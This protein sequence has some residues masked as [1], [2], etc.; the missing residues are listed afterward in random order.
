MNF[1]CIGLIILLLLLITSSYAQRHGLVIDSTNIS[2]SD[3]IR[4]IHAADDGIEIESA[5]DD[6]IQIS[7]ARE[8]GYYIF[9]A[10]K[11]GFWVFN[12]GED[13]VFVENAGHNG[14]RIKSTMRD[15]IHVES[16]LDD[17]VHLE[18]VSDD[19]FQVDNAGGDGIYI[20]NSDNTGVQV[21]RA[22]RN[23]VSVS[24]SG[25][26]GVS[27]GIAGVD[28]VYVQ[29]A[30]DDGI[31]VNNAGDDGVYI[32]SAGGDG[33]SVV[34]A[35]E[36]SMNIGGNKNSSG[37]PDAHIAQIYN[38]STDTS[39]DVLALKVGRTSNLG[40]GVNFI[41]FYDG[42]DDGVGRIEGNGT[43]G[44]LYGTTGSDF[45]ECLPRYSKED[46]I[47]EGDIIGVLNGSISHNTSEA[48]QLMIITDRPAV[49]GN[50]SSEDN[51][52][53]EKVSFIGQ[54]PVKVL[55]P[56][57]Q[58]DW[59]V[60]S[61]LHDGIG[62]AVSSK[63]LTLEH[64]IVGRAWESNS[65]QEIKKVNCAVGLDQ[66]EAK[67]AILQNMQKQMLGMQLQIDQLLKRN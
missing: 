64:R 54:V 9:N 4:I 60:P 20:V 15:G 14:M 25:E 49:L 37:G 22:G 26:D 33:L 16:A 35:A 31:H 23:G 62:R 12:A 51:Q 6:G 58:G 43:G 10:G 27:V 40:G 42:D 5:R 56:V 30:G 21:D 18:N 13:G 1:K 55:G 44:V 7:N 3:G 24:S 19:G 53:D 2:D 38:R 45:A 46:N 28:G 52:L 59:I 50:Q 61:G 65:D 39:P 48:I 32:L 34:S 63:A 41:S 17:G 29:S 8:N 66:S 57:K 36:F 47:E 67:D 11:L